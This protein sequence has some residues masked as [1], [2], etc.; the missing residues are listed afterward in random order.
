MQVAEAKFKWTFQGISYNNGVITGTL[1]SF[2]LTRKERNERGKK[3]NVELWQLGWSRINIH[4]KQRQT[5]FTIRCL[6]SKIHQV[7]SHYVNNLT[8]QSARNM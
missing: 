2:T 1:R 3:G 5:V 8:L 4:Y 7:I 6:Q